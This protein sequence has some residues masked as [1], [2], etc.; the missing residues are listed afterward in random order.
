MKKTIRIVLAAAMSMAMLTLAAC[1]DKPEDNNALTESLTYAVIWDGSAIAAGATIDYHPSLIETE[2]DF[3]ALDI[4]FEN[5]TDSDQPT[6]IKMEKVEG[7]ASM[8]NLM[9]CFGVTC[10]EFPIPWTSDV[11]T[12]HPG[13][14]EDQVLKVEYAPSQITSNTTFRL[15]VGKTAALNDPQ[16]VYIKFN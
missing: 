14:N 2:M 3:A 9:I 12:M 5:K 6:A 4:L 16:V 13:I 1:K 10:N 7:P 11:V 15:T 8:D